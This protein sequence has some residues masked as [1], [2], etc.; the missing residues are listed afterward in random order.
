MEQ[1]SLRVNCNRWVCVVINC[2]GVWVDIEKCVVLTRFLHLTGLGMLVADV[3]SG[4]MHWFADSYGS[5]DLPVV[6]KV[7]LLVT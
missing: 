3:L 4:L 5:V 2:G 6:G 7:I 1:P